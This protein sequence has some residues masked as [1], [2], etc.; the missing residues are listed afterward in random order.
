MTPCCN[1]TGGTLGI[2]ERG[3]MLM[4]PQVATIDPLL[5]NGFEYGPYP[6][7]VKVRGRKWFK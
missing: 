1:S 7:S 6:W 5:N 4:L 2:H 3:L